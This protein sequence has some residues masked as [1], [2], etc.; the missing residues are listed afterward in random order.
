MGFAEILTV[1]GLL[2]RLVQAAVK[3]WTQRTTEQQ[4]VAALEAMAASADKIGE[5]KRGE[6]IDLI[7]DHLKRLK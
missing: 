7:V 1:A 3:M 5:E 4:F 6:I 2:V